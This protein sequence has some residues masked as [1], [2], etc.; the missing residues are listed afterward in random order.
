MIRTEIGGKKLSRVTIEIIVNIGNKIHDKIPARLYNII[1]LPTAA[2]ETILIINIIC[3][4][5]LS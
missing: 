3:F 4:I 5:T 2:H 1:G